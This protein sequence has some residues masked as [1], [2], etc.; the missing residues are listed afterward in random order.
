MSLRP[1][2]LTLRKA[3]ALVWLVWLALL[4]EIAFSI[5]FQ[6]W[7]V[8]VVSVGTLIA[9]LLPSFF[10]AKFDIK[11]PTRF[12]PAIVLFLFATLFLGEVKDFYER[13]WW[14]DIL[15]HG[16]SAVAFGLFAF[17]FIFMLFEGDR[18]AAPPLAISFLS[19]CVAV[20][21]GAVWEIFEFGMDQA[22]GMNMQKSGLI[23]TMWDLI[24]DC[25]GAA[26]GAS[27]GY[28]YLK[29]SDSVLSGWIKRFV[30]KN[31]RRYRKLND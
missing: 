10:A 11:L 27:A 15:L 9:T 2:V 18:F 25:G 24:V 1:P 14:W 12:A 19:F 21:V 31:R 13:F 17:V 16:A 20:A 23:D 29:G 5:Y 30:R 4:T 7:H 3:P 8:L 6:R 28:L 26:I 22:F